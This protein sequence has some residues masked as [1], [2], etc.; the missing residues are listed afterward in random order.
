MD[1][2]EP[3]HPF[4]IG[5]NV[6][7]G[8]GMEITVLCSVAF[9]DDTRRLGCGQ[10]VWHSG[11]ARNLLVSGAQFPPQGSGPLHF[12]FSLL[13][14]HPCRASSEASPSPPSLPDSCN[15]GSAS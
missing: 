3:S 14:S 10:F 12:I 6:S 2:G 5:A 8:G 15:P 9:E 7:V 4:R 1:L 13:I 11:Y